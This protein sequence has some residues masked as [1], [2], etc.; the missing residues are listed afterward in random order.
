[1]PARVDAIVV[2]GGPGN[3]LGTAPMLAGKGS[4]R[5]LALSEGMFIE[6]FSTRL[7]WSYVM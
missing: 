5:Y 6:V 7:S 1:M 4:A 3:R 2:P